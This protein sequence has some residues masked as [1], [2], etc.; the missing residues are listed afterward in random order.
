M[1]KSILLLALILVTVPLVAQSDFDKSKLD[2]YLGSMAKYSKLSGSVAITASGNL[3]YENY[4]GTSSSTQNLE[5]D[6]DTK[7]RVGS[8]TKTFTA[9][10]IFQLIEENKLQ[11]NTFLASYFP[12][13]KNAESITI[14]QMLNHTSG[15]HNYTG[16]RKYQTY[17]E[18]EKSNKDLLK[19]FGS[20]PSDFEPG[21]SQ[22]Y[23][24]TAYVL[25]GMIIEKVTGGSYEEVIQSRIIEKLDLKRT[26]YGNKIEIEKNEAAP[27]IFKENKWVGFPTETNMSVPGGAGAMVSTVRDLSTFI[28]A[29]FNGKLISESSLNTM[30]DANNGI[31]YGLFTFSFNGSVAY[32]HNGGIDSFVSN[33]T[34]FPEEKMTLSVLANGVNTNFNSVVL[35]ILSIYYKLPFEIPD[36]S[37]K[38]ISIDVQELKNY[39]GNFSSEEFPLDLKFTVKKGKLMVVAT[40]QSEISLSSLSKFK[41]RYEPAGLVLIFEE[42]NGKVNYDH[43]K[44]QQQGREFSFQRMK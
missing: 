43:L 42:L 6:S 20:M 39:T 31:G 24:N 41:F 29:I 1:K 40:G 28:Y 25:L 7:F 32:G 12:D 14:K 2:N 4:F 16:D 11:L 23:S 21:S 30:K 33:M 26:E 34:Y 17:M 35:G 27:L 8:I 44:M 19:I 5:T 37:E 22:S 36:F 18:K 13:I 15:I 9:V 3:I 38:E 10:V